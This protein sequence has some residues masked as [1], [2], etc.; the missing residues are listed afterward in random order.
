MNGNEAMRWHCDDDNN[1]ADG[2]WGQ[3]GFI[4]AHSDFLKP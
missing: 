3:V 2:D 4:F 1:M